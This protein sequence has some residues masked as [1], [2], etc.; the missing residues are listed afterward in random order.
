M[1]PKTQAPVKS[2]SAKK[3]ATP[4]EKER[5]S[6]GGKLKARSTQAKKQSETLE[7]QKTIV[8]IRSKARRSHFWHPKGMER[9][10]RLIIGS[11]SKDRDQQTL[12]AE[13]CVSPGTIGKLREN[14]RNTD[15][16]TV[17][18][19]PEP[20]LILDLAPH[21]PSEGGSNPWF[22]MLMGCGFCDG[23][24]PAELF[25]GVEQLREFLQEKESRRSLRQ[26]KRKA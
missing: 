14:F 18:R 1:A 23:R 2:R 12:A 13:A 19:R 20:E 9:L 15:T 26:L 21:V 5:Y 22:L 6:V 4:P 8:E 24:D 16:K 7:K 25:E 17:M 11:I 10:C 3:I